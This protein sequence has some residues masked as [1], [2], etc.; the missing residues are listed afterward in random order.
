[1]PEQVAEEPTIP[2]LTFRKTPS[3][4]IPI[5]VSVPFNGNIPTRTGSSPSYLTKFLTER[6][7]SLTTIP[8]PTIGSPSS[9]RSP[10]TPTTPSHISPFPTPSPTPPAASAK[11]PTPTQE[12]FA[13]FYISP[14]VKY[15]TPSSQN[16]LK[17]PNPDPHPDNAN[18]PLVNINSPDIYDLVN[19]LRHDP[20]EIGSWV[21]EFVNNDSIMDDGPFITDWQDPPNNNPH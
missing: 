14:T 3:Q 6:P 10:F 18:D 5:N 2:Q 8:S 21:D 19:G 1:M 9:P 17:P 16:P 7:S 13:K 20:E 4:S 15:P 11:I 12:E